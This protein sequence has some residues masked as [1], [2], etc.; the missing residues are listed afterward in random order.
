MKIEEVPLYSK[1]L[2]NNP[3]RNDPAK[4]IKSVPIGKLGK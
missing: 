1:L 2:A 4:L 3:I